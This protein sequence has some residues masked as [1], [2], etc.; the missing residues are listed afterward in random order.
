MDKKLRDELGVMEVGKIAKA[1]AQGTN[2]ATILGWPPVV[3][4]ARKCSTAML[5]ST[6][7]AQI[8]SLGPA[9]TY[10]GPAPLR[11]TSWQPGVAELAVS[12]ERVYVEYLKTASATHAYSVPSTGRVAD[13]IEGHL[14]EVGMR[15][16]AGG[17][18]PAKAVATWVAEAVDRCYGEHLQ[19]VAGAREARPGRHKVVAAIQHAVAEVATNTED[20]RA[21]AAAKDNQFSDDNIVRALR[22]R[23]YEGAK[24]PHLWGEPCRHAV[25]NGAHQFVSTCRVCGLAHSYSAQG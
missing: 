11:Q 5:Y 8:E 7:V 2:V 13:A 21:V 15:L 20:G 14:K 3:D 24:C 6:F 16:W 17:E 18:W 25:G 19:G 23:L 22:K 9:P 4:L 12:V 10:P 1:L